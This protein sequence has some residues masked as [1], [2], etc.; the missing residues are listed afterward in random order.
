MSILTI[1]EKIDYIYEELR[2]QKRTRNLKIIL[3]I[4]IIW[5]IIFIYMTYFHPIDKEKLISEFSWTLSEYVNP[6]TQELLKNVDLKNNTT[7][8]I[9]N[10]I[11]KNN[12]NK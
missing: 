11:I 5:F 7:E 2:V 3:K 1:E 8:E 9:S 6:L 4:V 10:W 12:I